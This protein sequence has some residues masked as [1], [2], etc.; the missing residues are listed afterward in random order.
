MRLYGLIGN[1]LGHSR[2]ADYFNKKFREESID[3]EYRLYALSDVSGVES[4][5]ADMA[6]FNVTI[7]Y[8]RSI[9]PFLDALSAEAESVGA[10]N[11]VACRDGRRVGYNTDIEG[12]RHTL[13]LLLDGTEV[14]R[15]LV[16]GTGGA[17]VAVRYVLRERGIASAMVSRTAGRGDMT[18]DEL[19][20]SAV[21]RHKLIVNAT[22]AGMYPRV[23]EAPAIP[24]EAVGEGHFLF[25]AV[26][27]PPQ[28]LFLRHGQRRGA[29][30]IGGEEMF[31]AQAEASWRVWNSG[32]R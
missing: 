8:K 2:S 26:Y 29:R 24:Y 28:T 1:P 15:A 21:R 5:P 31:V 19:T 7:P 13:D 10:V 9:I 27:N 32:Q 25:D 23:D 14:E 11:C 22:P 30:I 4:L 3:A 20:E 17:A 18:Y 12:I 16:L 6:G